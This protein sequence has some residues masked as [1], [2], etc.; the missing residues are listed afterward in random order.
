MYVAGPAVEPNMTVSLLSSRDS[1]PNINIALAFNVSYGP[2][3]HIKCIYGNNLVLYDVRNNDDNSQ[4]LRE[5]IRSQYV[6]TSQ[7]DKTR[8]LIKVT[9]PREERI[10][11]CTVTVEGRKNII[12]GTYNYDPK[13]SGTS[14]TAITSECV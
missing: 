5:V 3:S 7:P 14:T 13:G 12:N 9:Q 4:I 1:G 8:V 2:P 6:S 11:T 10:Y